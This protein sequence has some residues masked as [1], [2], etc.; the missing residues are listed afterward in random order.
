MEALRIAVADLHSSS[1]RSFAQIAE[2]VTSGAR[3]RDD[4]SATSQSFSVGALFAETVS[5][6]QEMLK[7]I[8][9]RLQSGSP[10]DG[11]ESPERRLAAYGDHYKCRRS[12]MYMTI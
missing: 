9:E 10:R 12:V 5:G 4:L 1:E 8:G 2:I 11:A 3:L 6:A 7:E